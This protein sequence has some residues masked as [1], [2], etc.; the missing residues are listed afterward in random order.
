MRHFGRSNERED[1]GYEYSKIT[2]TGDAKPRQDFEPVMNFDITAGQ[3]FFESLRSYPGLY[4]P[5]AKTSSL[6]GRSVDDYHIEELRYRSDSEVLEAFYGMPPQDQMYAC[7][8][9]ANHLLLVIGNGCEIHPSGWIGDDPDITKDSPAIK[10]PPFIGEYR[11][12]PASVGY[13]KAC[14][15]TG[16]GLPET[17]E[18]MEERGE[19]VTFKEQPPAALNPS[20]KEL[21]FNTLQAVIRYGFETD[22]RED[23]RDAGQALRT[24]RIAEVA[25][26]RLASLYPGDVPEYCKDLVGRFP[27]DSADSGIQSFTA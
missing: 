15:A 4:F 16:M 25:F 20:F 9:V 5:A 12:Y 6:M 24:K 10:I 17:R 27:T 23:K 21:L 7:M 18:A 8:A 11:W 22:E 26:A 14:E 19:S 1:S 13:S 3:V 2:R